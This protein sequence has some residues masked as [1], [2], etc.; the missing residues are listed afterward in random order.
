MRRQLLLRFVWPTVCQVCTWIITNERKPRTL[1]M[2]F[3][4]RTFTRIFFFF[5]SVLWLTPIAWLNRRVTWAESHTATRSA[6]RLTTSTTLTCPPIRLKCIS[7]L[8][9]IPRAMEQGPESPTTKY[10]AIFEIYY[11]FIFLNISIV[12]ERFF[13][14]PGYSYRG[15]ISRMWCALVIPLTFLR[16]HS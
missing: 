6:R 8:E 16:P 3:L 4:A 15:N 13:Q 10:I 2:L 11:L 7:T 1:C 5:F 12:I 9:D 14:Q